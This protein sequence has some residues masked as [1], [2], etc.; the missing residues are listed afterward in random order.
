MI[1]LLHAARVTEITLL[2]TMTRTKTQREVCCCMRTGYGPAQYPRLALSRQTSLC[3]SPLGRHV[4][5]W[6]QV[7]FGPPRLRTSIGSHRLCNVKT[8]LFCVLHGSVCYTLCPMGVKGNE[9]GTRVI[10]PTVIEMCWSPYARLCLAS[11][12]CWA[13]QH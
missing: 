11:G 8:P 13:G 12:I 1:L 5:E 10:Q 4:T 2:R 6:L 3:S 7:F 9:N